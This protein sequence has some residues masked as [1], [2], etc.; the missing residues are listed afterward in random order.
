MQ[1]EKDFIIVATMSAP[2][3]I[4]L[5]L[6]TEF[7]IIDGIVRIDDLM[8]AAVKAKMPAVAITDI[9]NFFGLV[10]FYRAAIKNGIKPI[11]G[12]D[13][14][15]ENLAELNKPYKITLL[16]QND[17]GY[18]N[19]TKIIS[20]GYIVEQ[21]TDKPIIKHECLEQNCAGIIV[22]LG[23][24]SDLGQEIFLKK[25]QANLLLK[26]YTK[27]FPDRLYLE[28]QRTKRPNEEEF[29]HAAVD[30][31]LQ[32]K[33]PVVA[34]NDVR[35]IA[36]EDFEAHEA[37]VCINSGYVLAD[38][39]RPKEYSPLQYF[40]SAEEM[41]KLF[42]D[43]PEAIINT[44][45]IAK[46][47]N[48]ELQLGKT[49]LPNFPVPVGI[50][51]EDFFVEEAK[52]GLNARLCPPNELSSLPNNQLSRE[53]YE[54]RL[55][56]EIDVIKQ[57]GFV[58][59]FLIVA[60]FIKWSKK[61]G[62]PVG[63]GR[64]SGAGSLV[65]YSLNITDLDPIENN[66]L[67]ER[68]LNPER[69]SMP[70]FDVDFCMEGRDKVIEYVV[71]RYGKDCVSQ[72]ITFG[73]MAARAVVR[74]V[75]RVLGHPYGFVDKIAKLIPFE[76]GINLEK[77]LND[78]ELLRKRYNDEEEV[79]IL[80]DLAM[81]LEGIT[82]N[83]G[84]HAGGVVIAPSALT[85]F[86]PLYRVAG[87]NNLVSQFDKDDVEAVG[88][89]KFD[90][91]GL[92]T[93]T[94]INWAVSAINQ[95]RE[96]L[97]EPKLDIAQLPLDD[98]AT[99]KILQN[100]ETVAIFQVESRGMRDF[101]KRL[102][103]NCF[104]DIV[105]LG[106][107][108][109]PGP[110]Q[111]GMVDDFVDRKH[112]RQPISYFHPKLETVLR[113]TKG[114]I[115]Y[116]EQVMQ[117]AQ[118]LAGYSLGKADILRRAMGKKKPE[119]MTKQRAIFLEGAEKNGIDKHVANNIFDLMEKFSGYGFNRSHSACY[120]LITYQT[121]WLKA[122]YP[123]EFMAAVLSSDMDNTDK[124]VLFINECH[125]LK[126]NILPPNI[127][128]CVY[129]FF[130]DENKNIVYG[131][132]AIKGAGFAAIE[133]ILEKRQEGE[134]KNLYDFCRR[135]DTRKV[136]KKVFESLIC[137]GALDVFGVSRSRLFA[138]L[139]VAMQAAERA[140]RNNAIGQLDL[141]AD[142]NETD[143]YEVVYLD[144]PEWIDNER[145]ANEKKVL[146][147]YLSGHPIL[148]YQNEL[149]KIVSADIAEAKVIANNIVIIAGL[150]KASKIIMTK[151]GNRIAIVT[152]DD[153]TGTIDIA[154]FSELFNSMRDLLVE[155]NLLIFEG[156]VSLDKFS[157]ENRVRA[158]KI[159]TLEQ[160]RNVFA[161]ALVIKI[162]ATQ[163][164]EDAILTLSQ[165]LK[166]YCKGSCPVYIDYQNSNAS[167]KLYLGDAWKVN[168]KDGLLDELKSFFGN[169][170]VVVVYNS[171][172]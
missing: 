96:K 90:F 9:N 7:S 42:A 160:A 132:G 167:A 101:T 29:I 45:E 118:V 130:A 78:E 106:A 54:K 44:I 140:S 32:N 156:E 107:I 110:L 105:D 56:F 80:I 147:F 77:A 2:E 128:T 72:I 125:R 133:N 19:I 63:P 35:F 60:D 25:T 18:K 102:Q 127:N 52:N 124:V 164:S 83:A 93:L 34:T 46:R 143:S 50:S 64:G 152:I 48:V 79:K 65:A 4:H 12:A 162:A 8:E 73:T 123:A 53:I 172:K 1:L 51:V 150:V 122:H 75:G 61:N 114:V 163:I 169:E 157:G 131:L 146:G 171:K 43:I 74:D 109:R 57:M 116:Q 26:F 5:K 82:R 68:F 89:V 15:L 161:S 66:L 88:L 149:Q 71:N 148:K 22:M 154:V 39:K 37:R 137:A 41:K 87:E 121:A 17:L 98:P 119:E 145:L 97:K 129:K 28:L 166:N 81:K 38:Q 126:L 76:L 120:A 112:G 168:L 23:I 115:L 155:D 108:Y 49:F 159:L 59:Y 27:L 20:E 153:H 100:G 158:N 47:C 86:V 13:I 91:L 136:N 103:P 117:I 92:R 84:K 104:D 30:F 151:S 134:F 3:F 24:Y 139:P 138:T 99:Y 58:G 6:H 33:I 113:S 36:A 85:N 135:V 144:S 16:A 31:A 69:V 40:K 142:T 14:W 170:N 111:S 94:I 70:D 10:K 62:I 55:Q 11:I 67:F 141:F 21:I 165:K 95:L